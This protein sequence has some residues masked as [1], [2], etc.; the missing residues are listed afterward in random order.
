MNGIQLGTTCM[1]VHVHMTE[2][3]VSMTCIEPSLCPRQLKHTLLNA[4]AGSV[5]M[6]TCSIT[7][8]IDDAI[9]HVYCQQAATAQ[10]P[11]QTLLQR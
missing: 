9:V 7:V 8:S 6:D 11:A 5:N 10:A 3:C 1:H 4:C 2:P